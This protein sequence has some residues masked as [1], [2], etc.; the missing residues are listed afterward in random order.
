M[1]SMPGN[2]D[3]VGM[4]ELTTARTDARRSQRVLLCV[5]ILARS[6]PEDESPLTEET[7]ALVVNAHGALILLEMRVRPGQRLL[8]R[9]WHTAREQECTVVHVKENSS[10]KNEVGIAFASPRPD[11]WNIAFPPDNSPPLE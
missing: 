7:T 8:V 9:N 10:A 1:T 2:D 4:K 11:F 3:V 6:Y 5:P